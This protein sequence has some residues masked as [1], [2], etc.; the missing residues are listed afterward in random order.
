M[1]TS[2][3]TDIHPIVLDPCHVV[4][5]LLIK[6]VDAHLLHPGP[7]RVFAEI[8][9]AST[10]SCVGD[11]P[12]R[13]N[14]QPEV[15]MMAD[16]PPARL[17]ILKPLFFSTGVD[18]F[19]PYVIKVGRRSEKLWGVI[20]K[21]LTT[22]CVHLDLLNTIEADGFLLALRERTSVV[23]RELKEAFAA[24]E[25]QLQERLAKQR[26]KFK[27][28][29]PAAPH[30]GGAWEGEIQAVKKALQVVIGA[31]SL[32]EEVLLT[33][34]INVEG[35]VRRCGSRSCDTKH[36]A[37]GAAGHLLATIVLCSRPTHQETVSGSGHWQMMVDHFWAQFLR[38]Y[39]PSL[40]V[41]QK[42]RIRSAEVQVGDKTYLR[43]VARLVRLPAVPDD[44]AIPGTSVAP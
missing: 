29:P 27:F 41:R 35:I 12:S 24:M 28:N 22:R 42:W 25:P 36:V 21:C 4:T 5:R 11:R 15:P 34:L 38:S 32:Q 1:D 43:P 3:S 31:Q 17:L 37:D 23:Q 18:C 26:I 30:F 10:G 2:C 19:G 40:Q 9:C 33:V 6:D 14:G 44:D 7:N 39:L 13:G 8:K 16:L 20:F